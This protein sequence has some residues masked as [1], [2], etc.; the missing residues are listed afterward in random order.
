MY[1]I[2]SD[3][4]KMTFYITDHILQLVKRVLM[5]PVATKNVPIRLMD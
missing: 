5:D 3:A 1:V 2:N 4:Q